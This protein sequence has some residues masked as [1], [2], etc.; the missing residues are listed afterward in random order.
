MKVHETQGG[1]LAVRLRGPGGV[2]IITHVENG[3][4]TVVHNPQPFATVVEFPFKDAVDHPVRSGW[5][6][7][8]ATADEKNAL[9]R[10]EDLR[11]GAGKVEANAFVKS[12]GPEIERGGADVPQEHILIDGRVPAGVGMEHEFGDHQTVAGGRPLLGMARYEGVRVRPGTPVS[13]TV[14]QTEARPVG[15][16]GKD[17][18]A[19]RFDRARTVRSDLFLAFSHGLD[20]VAA[21]ECGVKAGSSWQSDLGNPPGDSLDVFVSFGVQGEVECIDRI[22]GAAVIADRRF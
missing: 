2:I 18:A 5:I 9:S 14:L 21:R 8:L 20:L 12:Q 17:F 16:A 13:Q 3:S 11:F 7:R 19:W 22:P 4:I 15:L 1:A 6:R 10:C